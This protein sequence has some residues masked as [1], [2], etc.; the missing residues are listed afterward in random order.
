[1]D[2]NTPDKQSRSRRKKG[3]TTRARSLRNAGN[4]AEA[5]LWEE[6]RD[7]RLGGYKFVRQFPLGPYYADFLC[8]E[9]KLVVELDGSQHAGRASDRL[10]D[11]HMINEGYSVLR[12]WS[13]EV[14]TQRRSICETILG[15]LNRQLNES[16]AASDLR[17]VKSAAT[18][19][20]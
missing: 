17:Y 7:R 18:R 5:L 4:Q 10:R 9:R 11:A 6:L 13:H 20:D 3:T 12:F 8:R 2:K 1:M 14:A 15:A 16:V 19:G